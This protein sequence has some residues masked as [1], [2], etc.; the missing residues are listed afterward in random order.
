MLSCTW[1]CAVCLDAPA[2]LDALFSGFP[3]R[4][5]RVQVVR[6]VPPSKRRP[7]GLRFL[8]HAGIG[9]GGCHVSVGGRLLLPMTGS[10]AAPRHNHGEALQ[11]QSCNSNIP[12]RRARRPRNQTQVLLWDQLAQACPRLLKDNNMHN[13]SCPSCKRGL[14][15]CCVRLCQVCAWRQ[16]SPHS[17]SRSC[18]SSS[19]VRCQEHSTSAH[20][21]VSETCG[22]ARG[23]SGR[24]SKCGTECRSRFWWNEALASLYTYGA[25]TSGTRWL[26]Q[27][28]NETRRQR[29]T[30]ARGWLPEI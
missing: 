24:S 13:T 9:A 14:S 29:E 5:G 6:E 20:G 8:C 27:I 16:Q 15:T 26:S 1:C 18:S 3:G 4:L 25:Y 7:P 22:I 11:H 23:P 17:R 30:V 10:R 19:W 21:W 2:P 28:H 12:D